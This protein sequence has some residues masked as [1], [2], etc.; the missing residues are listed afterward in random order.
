MER[1][2]PYTYGFKVTVQSDHKPLET[3][4]RNPLLTAIKMLQGMILNTEIWSTV[5]V[6]YMPGRD[7]KHYEQGLPS[8]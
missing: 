4:L 7:S 5:E 3:T 6:V 8:W 2:N 1:F